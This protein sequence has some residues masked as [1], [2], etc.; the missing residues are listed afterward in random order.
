MLKIKL[1]DKVKALVTGKSILKMALLIY[2]YL[3]SFIVGV[4]TD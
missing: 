1:I 2:Y 3:H 4:R